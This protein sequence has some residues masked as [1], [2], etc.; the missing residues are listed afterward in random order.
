MKERLIKKLFVVSKMFYSP[1]H[2]IEHWRRVERNGLHLSKFTKADTA[3]VNCFAYVHDCMRVN[4]GHDPEH[5][6]SMRKGIA[7]QHSRSY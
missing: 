3:I 7:R 1:L 6:K 4:E 2:G 5:G